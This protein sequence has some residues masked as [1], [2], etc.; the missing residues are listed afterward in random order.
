MPA[1]HVY[2]ADIRPSITTSLLRMLE[3]L[4]ENKVRLTQ[5][6]RIDFTG[7]A[8]GTVVRREV[9][10]RFEPI[11]SILGNLDDVIIAYRSATG[12]FFGYGFYNEDSNLCQPLHPADVV[13]RMTRPGRLRIEHRE[14][15]L[16]MLVT[17]SKR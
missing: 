10:V 17:L 13:E 7:S 9:F 2:V 16:M 11:G 3:D 15:L 5:E 6:K 14:L 4:K 1:R 8:R 12:D